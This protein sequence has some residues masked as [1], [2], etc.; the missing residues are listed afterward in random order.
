M[1][2]TNEDALHEVLKRGKAV[3]RRKERRAM[4]VTAG[5][6]GLLLLGLI[7]VIASFAGKGISGNANP[8]YG[9]FL[10]SAEAGGYILTAVIAFAIGVTVTVLALKYRNRKNE[11]QES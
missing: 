2:F 5:V 7:V 4:R 3:R 10:L 11:D 6:T 1:R 9:A 8:A